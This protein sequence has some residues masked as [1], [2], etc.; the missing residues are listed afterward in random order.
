MCTY[1]LLQQGQFYVN[2]SLHSGHT[3][4]SMS[5]VGAVSH[6]EHRYIPRCAP[7]AHSQGLVTLMARAGCVVG[8]R[9]QPQ[10]HSS[11]GVLWIHQFR[12]HQ[13]PCWCRFTTP[14]FTTPVSI[15]IHQFAFQS[16]E[17]GVLLQFTSPPLNFVNCAFAC[18]FVN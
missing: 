8:G 9:E 5:S 16:G 14:V 7:H 6:R 18:I 11:H 12:F 15:W 2:T 3:G 4:I 1:S 17:L 10:V 13:C